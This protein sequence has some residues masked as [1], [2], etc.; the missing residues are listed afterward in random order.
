[1]PKTV[2]GR[3]RFGLTPMPIGHE[4]LERDATRPRGGSAPLARLSGATQHPYALPL[5]DHNARC[6]H[7]Q[8]VVPFLGEDVCAREKRPGRAYGPRVVAANP[9]EHDHREAAL[10]CLRANVGPVEVEPERG[11]KSQRCVSGYDQEQLVQ[12]GDL[13]GQLKSIVELVPAMDNPPESVNREPLWPRRLPAFALPETA[14][15][16]R[17]GPIHPQ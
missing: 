11:I 3:K 8:P 15:D 12:S 7:G 5:V 17:L 2:G 6:R 16:V 9:V 14:A 10:G 13:C 4:R 1:M